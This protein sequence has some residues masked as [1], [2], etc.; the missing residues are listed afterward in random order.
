MSVAIFVTA[1]L[2]LIGWIVWPEIR[3]I[4]DKLKDRHD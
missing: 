3:K 1:M 4:I 2:C